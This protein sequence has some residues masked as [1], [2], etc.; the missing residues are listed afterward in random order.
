MFKD[1]PCEN[2]RY[3]TARTG[4][5]VTQLGVLEGA[6][7]EQDDTAEEMD[8][9]FQTPPETLTGYCLVLYSFFFRLVKR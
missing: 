3:T 4:G 2:R 8:E 6:T 7:G 1:V 5:D 9:I